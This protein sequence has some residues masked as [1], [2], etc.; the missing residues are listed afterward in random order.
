VALAFEPAE[1]DELSHRPR[2][3]REPVFNRLMLERV[4]VNALVMGAFAFAVFRW[5]LAGGASV[6]AARN[7]TLLLMVLFENV[8]VLNS[9]SEVTSIFR[10]YILGNP[11]L[12]FGMLGAQGIHIAAMYTPGLRDILQ[13][14]P[15]TIHLWSQLLAVALVLIAVDELHKLWHGRRDGAARY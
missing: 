9:R 13:I 1:G 8:H 7:V 6:E 5:Q 15:V 14:T 3:P 12:L 4:I 2:A 10:Q 11:L